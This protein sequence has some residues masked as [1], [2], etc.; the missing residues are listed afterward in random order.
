MSMTGFKP[1]PI[2][3]FRSVVQRP[4]TAQAIAAA[5]LCNLC[6]EHVNVIN[7]VADPDPNPTV[8]GQLPNLN[9]CNSKLTSETRRE[10][11]TPNTNE[12]N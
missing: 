5:K 4:T 1:S 10:T 7:T 12:W 8:G 3:T 6:E 11:L 9:E 2:F